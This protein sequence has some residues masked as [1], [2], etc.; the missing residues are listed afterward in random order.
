[1]STDIEVDGPIPGPH[2]MLSLGSAA[3]TGGGALLAT[4]TANLEELPEASGHPEALAWWATNPGAWAAARTDPQPPAGAMDRYRAWLAGLPGSPVFVGHPAAFDFM[5]V[6]WYLIT[7]AGT[8]PF[9]R[10]ALDIRTYAMGVLGE[11]FREYTLASLA[12]R[13][14]PAH[15]HTHIALDD[16]IE[17]GEIFCALLAERRRRGAW[18]EGE[19]PDHVSRPDG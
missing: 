8:S 1:M 19:E 15:P 10:A 7:F 11:P 3:F 12:A 2:S 17:Q 18:P 6:Y 14:S 4:F 16:A 9:G 5:F 13:F